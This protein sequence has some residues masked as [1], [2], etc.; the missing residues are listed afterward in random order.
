MAD[1]INLQFTHE[2]A[3]PGLMASWREQPPEAIGDAGFQLHDEAVET[4]MYERRY[5]DATTRIMNLS[6]FGLNRLWGGNTENYFR[7]S[8]RF[9]A[10]GDYRSRVTIVGN[11]PEETRAALGRYAAERGTVLRAAGVPAA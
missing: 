2:G 6:S 1:E 4:L 5:Q 9:D 7:I 8:V 11:A 10:D 3:A